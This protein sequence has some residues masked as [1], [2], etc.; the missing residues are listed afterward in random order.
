MKCWKNIQYDV[1][2]F[3]KRREFEIIYIANMN[4]IS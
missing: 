1:I 2:V 4:G 3:I